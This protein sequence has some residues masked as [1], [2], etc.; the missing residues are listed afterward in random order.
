M[1]R[2]GRNHHKKT[3]NKPNTLGQM[4]PSPLKDFT[5]SPIAEFS[6][7][8]DRAL[9]SPKSI[10]GESISSPSISRTFG[11]QDSVEAVEDSLLMLKTDST[12]LPKED[13]VLDKMPESTVLEENTLAD[14]GK[15]DTVHVGDPTNKG[16]TTDL[17][18]GPAPKPQKP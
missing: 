8:N 13:K 18:E 11:E 14:A 12:V 2:G 16:K 6:D 9:G 10:N 1:A 5:E 3:P 7:S 17:P 15:D 4:G